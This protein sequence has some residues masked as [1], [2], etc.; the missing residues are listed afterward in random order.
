MVM[1]WLF[2]LL[3][4]NPLNSLLNHPPRDLASLL[5]PAAV[6]Q[7]M[8]VENVPTRRSSP[9]SPRPPPPIST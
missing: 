4:V 2:I 5:N 8:N 6:L 9:S 7:T 3:V 1:F